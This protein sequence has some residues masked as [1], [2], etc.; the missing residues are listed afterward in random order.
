MTSVPSSPPRSSR[1]PTRAGRATAVVLGLTAI[2][3]VSLRGLDHVAPWVRGEPRGTRHYSSIEALE[4][5][6]GTQLVLP[7]YFPDT[8]TWPPAA[9][10]R[11]AGDGRPT[12]V[13]FEGHG[14]HR[15]RFVV[16]QC[17]DGECRLPARLLSPGRERT[18][19]AVSIAG[20]AAQLVHGDDPD[21]GAFVEL[22]MSQFG[23]QIVLRLYD[24][25]SATLLRLARSLR[26]GRP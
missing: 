23:R 2:M 12:S 20:S 13:V 18:R 21:A 7:I 8:F 1:G 3:A 22:E 17:L 5:E 16:A 15:T 4:R 6:A 10:I 26:R 24:D 25:D 9:V 14:Q 19:V 11:G